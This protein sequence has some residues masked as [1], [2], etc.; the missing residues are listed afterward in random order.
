MGATSKWHFFLGLPS[1]SPKIKTLI[2]L[3]LWI[4]IYS[5]KQAYLEYA[6]PISYNLQK[7]FSNNVLH[8]PTEDQLIIVLMGFV[9]QS[10][11]LYL[12]PSLS[13]EHNSCISNLNEQC[14]CTLG[15]YT[16][17]AFQW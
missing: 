13:F 1:G 3:K 2:V 6:K 14:K 4:L 17:K 8:A 10:Q 7:G 11:I 15:I 16:S 12:T 5:S 9:I